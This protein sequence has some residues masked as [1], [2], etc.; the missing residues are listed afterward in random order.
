MNQLSTAARIAVVGGGPAGIVVAKELQEAG[1]EPIVLE[2]SAGLGGQ[3]NAGAPHSGVWPGMRANTS[4]AMTRFSDR[5]TPAGW[6]VFPRAE[7]VGRELVEYANHFGVA[8]RVRLG[9]RVVAAVAAPDGDGWDVTIEETADGSVATRRFAAVVGCSGR[10]AQPH[11]PAADEL[12]FGARVAVSHAA[13]YRGRD[14]FRGRRVLVLGNSISGLEIAADLALDPS[15]TVVSACRRP[16]W[17]IPKLA[18]GVPAD[19]EW[20]T[21]FADLLGRTLAPEELSAGL[22]ASLQAAAGDPA[23][24]GGLTPDPDL[25]ATG[26]SQSQHYLPLVAEGRID[27]RPG[28]A[29]VAGDAVT[30][31]DGTAA[32]VDAVVLATGYDVSMPYL[33]GVDLSGLVGHTFAPEHPGLALMGQYVLHGPYFPVLELQARWITAVWTGRRE[34]A[35]AP[36][37]PALPF[38]VHHQLAGAFAS[39][40]GAAPD[41]AAHPERA[42]ALLFGPMLP[43]RYRLADPAAA[44]RYAQ[45]TAGFAPAPEQIGL[46]EA[47]ALDDPR[48]AVAGAAATA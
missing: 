21:A 25:L 44:A 19:Q 41:P 24:V 20:F 15:I 29:A 43:E 8:Q 7:D 38:Y 11:V 34:L 13:A 35:G 47:L 31:A 46:L 33:D 48:R 16:R 45:A 26:L 39:A 18:R 23:A 4:G 36:P 37:L 42:D 3:W 5:P 27:V 30:F 22:R 32:T 2:Q 28:I 1:L 10:F 9:A 14:A 12:P 17:I 6:P 40:A